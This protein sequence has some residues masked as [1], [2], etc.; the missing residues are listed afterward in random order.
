MK[1]VW[2]IVLGL[3]ICIGAV[4]STYSIAA[5]S[6]P[7][8]KKAQQQLTKIGYDPG[9]VDGKMGQKTEEAIKNFQ[10]DNALTITG[11]LNEETLGKLG[12]DLQRT[13]TKSQKESI[14]I[15]VVK[16]TYID[17]R[18]NIPI[19]DIALV[20][21]AIVKRFAE[22]A[23]AEMSPAHQEDAVLTLKIWATGKASGNNYSPVGVG[24][25]T[26]YYTAASLEGQ[27][28]LEDSSGATR[29]ERSFA[30]KLSS[31]SSIDTSQYST[32][33]ADSEG[34]FYKALEESDGFLSK[35]VE[36]FGEVYGSQFFVAA[37]QDHVAG[38]IETAIRELNRVDEAGLQSLLDAHPVGLEQLKMG[39]ESKNSEV[40]KG[41][42]RM[43][44]IINDPR[45]IEVLMVA[46]ADTDPEVA[47]RAQAILKEQGE[48]ALDD[49]I[50]AFKNKNPYVRSRAAEVVGAIHTARSIEDVC[51]ALQDHEPLV[52]MTAAS[53]IEQMG[54]TAVNAV[55]SLILALQDNDWKVRERV[56][57]A[58]GATKDIRA[59]APLIVILKDDPT[60][61]VPKSVIEAL[62]KITNQSFGDDHEAWETWWENSM[63]NK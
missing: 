51:V 21:D 52:R 14:Q 57:K 30:G 31:P 7:V 40:R 8:V 24:K 36:I 9:P 15:I 39:F 46:L 26:Y 62:Q 6:D 38:V 20:F 55:E 5:T 49:L 43:L 34:L 2:I 50:A 58:L 60:D 4:W 29:A 28:I 59:V 23:N 16:Q 18:T 13:V 1:N 42:V 32:S 45:T 22:Y 25:G 3:M 12:I 53:A 35:I 11:T 37:L 56:V 17:D 61:A 54:E 27:I 44:G 33:A 41:T 19:P 47:A 48:E 10:R 63:G